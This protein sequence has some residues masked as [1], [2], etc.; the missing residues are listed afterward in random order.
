MI[1]GLSSSRAA[2]TSNKP[3]SPDSTQHDSTFFAHSGPFTPFF[4]QTINVS[5]SVRAECRGEAF[6]DVRSCLPDS[7]SIRGKL[8]KMTV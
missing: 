2:Q 8:T 6:R 5:V 1:C 7:Q 3:P 4:L